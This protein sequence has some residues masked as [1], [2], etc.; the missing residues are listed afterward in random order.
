MI[1]LQE[2]V[3]HERQWPVPTNCMTSTKIVRWSYNRFTG[4]VVHVIKSIISYGLGA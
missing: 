3:L 1:I 2:K 4:H